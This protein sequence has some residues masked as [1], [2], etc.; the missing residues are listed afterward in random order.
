MG[1]VNQSLLHRRARE[2]WTEICKWID[3]SLDLKRFKFK[4]N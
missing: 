4:K 2:N 3:H 1:R